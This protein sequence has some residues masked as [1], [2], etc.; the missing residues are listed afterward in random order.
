[1]RLE[2]LKMWAEKDLLLE[3]GR[4]EYGFLGFIKG[5]LS[6]KEMRCE[7]HMR[8]AVG[9]ELRYEYERILLFLQSEE[10]GFVLLDI[11]SMNRYCADRLHDHVPYSFN[12]ECW[13]FRIVNE[14]YVWYL[15]C[16]P[17]NEKKSFT[18]FCYDR[19]KLMEALSR[20]KGLPESCYGTLSFTGER[21]RIRFG[22]DQ[23]ESFPQYGCNITENKAFAEEQNKPFR[24]T[25]A[26][27]AAMENGSIYGWDTPMAEPKNYDDGGH[28]CPPSGER[29]EKNK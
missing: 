3:E 27:V 12:R 22:E 20:D 9:A 7:T 1:M 14:G 26:Q 2:S 25:A 5:I 8:I 16:T 17:W 24:I 10:A 21:I 29:R 23:Y 13:G 28:F 11:P 15:G 4:E 18:L 19:K 6:D